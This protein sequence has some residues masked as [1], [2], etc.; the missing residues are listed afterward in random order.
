MKVGSENYAFHWNRNRAG[1]LCGIVHDHEKIW[2]EMVVSSTVRSIRI[3]ML[4]KKLPSAKTSFIAMNRNLGT[5]SICRTQT[6]FR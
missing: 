2:D 3:Q 6:C 4:R 1:E 5:G